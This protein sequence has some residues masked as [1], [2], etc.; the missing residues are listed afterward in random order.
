MDCSRS[1]E[2]RRLLRSQAPEYLPCHADAIDSRRHDAARIARAL[3]AWVQ[4]RDTRR[5]QRCLV[6]HDADGRGASGFNAREQRTC[7][8]VSFNATVKKRDSLA[9]RLRRKAGQA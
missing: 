2:G 1:R 6:A 4:P 3:A 9:Q 7:I 8:P 5:L